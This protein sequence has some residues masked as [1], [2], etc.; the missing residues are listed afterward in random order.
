MFGLNVDVLPV[1]EFSEFAVEPVIDE[2][3]DAVEPESDG[4]FCVTLPVEGEIEGCAVVPLVTAE[5]L[6]PDAWLSGMQS[7]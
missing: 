1:T 2:F 7:W 6:V 3:D 5:E 4:G